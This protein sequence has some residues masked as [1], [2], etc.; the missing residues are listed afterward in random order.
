MISNNQ[1]DRID[2]S[3][4]PT[5]AEALRSF[6]EDGGHISHESSF[7]EDPLAGDTS[8]IKLRDAQ[9]YPTLDSFF[10]QLVNGDTNPFKEGL[11][12]FI[13]LTQTFSS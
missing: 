5:A 8:L 11:L 2:P 3:I 4:V 12:F 6:E 7:G 13:H 1:V 9:R 10:H